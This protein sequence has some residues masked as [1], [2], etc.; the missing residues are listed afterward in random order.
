MFNDTITL[1]NKVKNPNTHK[2]EWKKTV[3]AGCNWSTKTIRNVSGST[4][5]ISYTLSCRILYNGTQVTIN[6]GDYAV[7]GEVKDEITPDNIVKVINSYRPN[8]FMI[9]SL[10][11]N[12]SGRLKHYHIE[13]V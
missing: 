13:G 4:T 6:V 7:K 2:D 11:D 3:L 8:A 12:T 1:L 5:S 10:K 9:K